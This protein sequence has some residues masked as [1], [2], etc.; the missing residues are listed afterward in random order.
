[1]GERKGDVRTYTE[2]SE[3]GLGKG[4]TGTFMC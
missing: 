4:G 2:T 3:E 1:M